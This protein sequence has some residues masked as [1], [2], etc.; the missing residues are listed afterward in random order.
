ML[1]S[2]G[3][4]PRAKIPITNAPCRKLP[5]LMAYTCIAKVNPHGRKNVS[6]Q[7]INAAVF[8]VWF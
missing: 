4:V 7:V 6:A 8:G 1:R 2:H 3:T 5:V